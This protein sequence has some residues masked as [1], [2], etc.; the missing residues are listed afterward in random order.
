MLKKL[1]TTI[2]QQKDSVIAWQ[3]E[4]TS[5]PALGPDNN[6]QGEEAKARWILKE[7]QRIGVSDIEE[8][9]AL[10]SRVSCGFR[11]NIVA[12]IK[13]KTAQTLWIISHM[14]VVPAG[15]NALWK[16]DPFCLHVDGDYIYGRGVEDNQQ[17]IA[18]SFL[19]AKTLLETKTLPYL[20]LGLI[21]V[22]DEETGMSYGLPHVLNTVPK[23]IDK[24]DL[25]LVPDLGNSAG[26]MV[27]IAEKSCLWLRFTVFGKQCHASTPQ[28]GVNTLFVSS[29]C[30]LALEQL[31][32]FFRKKDPLYSP[33][34]STFV[35][36]KKEA[37]VENINTISGKDVFYLDCRILPNYSIENVIAKS[38]TIVDE[39][40][41]KFNARIEVDVV[42]QSIAPKAT[43]AD[44]P[45]VKKLLACLKNTLGKEG[46]L[47]GSGGQTVASHLR[48]RGINTAVWS[49]LIPNPHTPNERSSIPNTI[50]DAK[51]MLAMLFE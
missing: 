6:G 48:S 31:Y 35:P 22:S 47:A 21:F 29:A 37:N 26:T 12:R 28:H 17:A 3:K 19:I 13:G 40:A 14:D 9:P 46:Q 32:R 51:V 5:R 33:S 30:V 16:T 39:V 27:E 2:E 7:L 41:K 18:C 1:L 34:W 44:S 24:D 20:T 43:G 42:H 25:V 38:K 23:L 15:E 49:T 4:L 10:D 50:N 36:S 45:V 11:P 8:Y